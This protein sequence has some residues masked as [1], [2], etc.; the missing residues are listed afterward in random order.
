MIQIENR[1]RRQRERAIQ[2]KKESGGKRQGEIERV[3]QKKQRYNERNTYREIGRKKR[4]KEERK[5]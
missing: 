2:R 4:N 5:K 1:K 3:R